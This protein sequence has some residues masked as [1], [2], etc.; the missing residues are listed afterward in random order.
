MAAINN[1]FSPQPYAQR[2]IIKFESFIHFHMQ[3]VFKILNSCYEWT[4]L[5]PTPSA[6]CIN[7]TQLLL[8]INAHNITRRSV[9][10]AYEIHQKTTAYNL[11][12]TRFVGNNSA[13]IFC[14][15]TSTAF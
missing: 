11:H 1:L 9:L 4:A 13:N 2:T 6:C 7:S 8:G 12:L 3:Q 15:A 5:I 14:P 10:G